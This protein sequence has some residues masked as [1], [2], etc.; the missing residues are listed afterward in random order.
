MTAKKAVKKSKL[1][2]AWAGIEME[3]KYAGDMTLF[4][5]GGYESK[6][7]DA[8]TAFNKK[9]LIMNQIYFG[10]GSCNVGGAGSA[11]V[12][13]LY[14]ELMLEHSAPNF[15]IEFPINEIRN[16]LEFISAG[17]HVVL[18][19]RL[20]EP[21]VHEQ[22]INISFKL[23]EPFS[24]NLMMFTAEGNDVSYTD[25]KGMYKDDIPLLYA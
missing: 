11:K 21:P 12:L 2:I 15:T 13:N 25:E 7:K 5:R 16:A 17:F 3:G 22:E 10:A 20:P 18:T 23:L 9:K 24:K 14:R 19:T 4:I 8:V 6:I 1:L